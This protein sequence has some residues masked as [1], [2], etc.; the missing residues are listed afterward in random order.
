MR[1]RRRPPCRR[2]GP[3][4]EAWRGAYWPTV[5][6][7]RVPPSRRRRRDPAGARDA[8]G[9][10]VGGTGRRWDDRHDVGAVADHVLRHHLD[11][12]PDHQPD[13]DDNRLEQLR[14][15]AAGV[16]EPRAEGRPA[17][18]GRRAVRDRRRGPRPGPAGPSRR[19]GG[20]AG[21]LERGPSGQCGDRSLAAG[22]R[23]SR[24]WRRA[25]HRRRPGGRPGPAPA[26]FRLHRHAVGP[27][28]GAGGDRRSPPP[29]PWRA[30]SRRSA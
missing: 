7:Q 8:G 26:R 27:E 28:P 15:A 19:R 24:G 29:P 12:Q 25:A 16:A 14:A 20:P 30:S 9:V 17:G 11:H 13:T 4:G 23:R 22:G 5:P 18:D 1:R 3:P 2:R 10:L 21:Y 6:S